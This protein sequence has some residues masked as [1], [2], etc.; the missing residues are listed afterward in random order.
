MEESKPRHPGGRPTAY[1]KSY[2]KIAYTLCRQHG[3]TDEKLA[4]LFDVHI[5]SIKYWKNKHPEFSSALRKGKDE[6]DSEYVETA[7]LKRAKGFVRKSV[8]KRTYV[9]FGR[10]RTETQ[11]HLDEVPG[12]VRACEVWLYN[13]NPER[14]KRLT[15]EDGSDVPE[16]EHGV[17]VV[18]EQDDLDAWLSTFRKDQK[19]DGPPTQE[20]NEIS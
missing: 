6:F 18:P 3:Y 8:T 15:R 10:E 2:V 12:N 5:S 19:S 9:Y 11:E 20:G 17:L 1:R 16:D 14:W 7:L 13:R 4:E